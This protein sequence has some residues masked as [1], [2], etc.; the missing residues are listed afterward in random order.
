MASMNDAL[1]EA[2]AS[3]QTG[4]NDVVLHTLELQ[5]SSFVNTS[6]NSDGVYTAL[7]VVRDYRNHFFYLEGDTNTA[8]VDA[9]ELVEFV[10]YPFNFTLPDVR[11]TGVP[12]LRIEID[13]AGRLVTKYL[14]RAILS[15]EP[16]IVVYRPYLSGQDEGNIWPV[17]GSASPMMSPLPKFSIQHAEITST[18]IIAQCHFRDLLNKKFPLETYTRFRF[19]GLDR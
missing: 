18:K 1:K 6:G 16:V 11:E 7:R 12:Q 8:G 10:G 9:G 5:H 19:P 15:V 14:E 13:N 3:A 2:Y 4:D 17:G